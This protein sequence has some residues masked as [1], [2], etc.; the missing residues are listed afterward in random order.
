M[1]TIK[2]LTKDLDTLTKKLRAAVASTY[3]AGSRIK[4]MLRGR[5]ETWIEAEVE[6]HWESNTYPHE[7]IVRNVKTGK[8]RNI[9][10]HPL[11]GHRIILLNSKNKPRP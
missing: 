7:I 8:R 10:T 11:T 5:Q 6:G 9:S 3:P 2:A 4:V 1:K